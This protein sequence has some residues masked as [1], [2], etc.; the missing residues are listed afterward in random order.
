MGTFGLV[1]VRLAAVADRCEGQ[2]WRGQQG[3]APGRMPVHEHQPIPLFFTCIL[4]R[5]WPREAAP[6]LL[7]VLFIGFSWLPLAFGLYA[8]QSGVYAATGEFLLGRG[9]AHALYIGFFGSLLVAMVTRVT[10]GHSGRPLAMPNAGWFAFIVLQAVAVVRV[11][12]EVMPDAG[13]WQALA[14]ISWLLA[15]LPWVL[16]HLWI[17]LVPRADGRPG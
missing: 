13:L 1:W 11:L 6:G 8:M 9:P 4:L 14:A 5:W 3:R 17:Y 7:W 10:Q 2:G 16:R 12:A 15:F